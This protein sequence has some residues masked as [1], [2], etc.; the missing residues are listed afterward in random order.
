MPPKCT[1]R[2]APLRCDRPRVRAPRPFSSGHRRRASD[3]PAAS[4]GTSTAR[5]RRHD[6]DAVP[7]GEDPTLP[8]LRGFR[9]PRLLLPAFIVEARPDAKG[10]WSSQAFVPTPTPTNPSNGAFSSPDLPPPRLVARLPLL[11]GLV[12]SKAVSPLWA[13][14]RP[15]HRQGAMVGSA[16]SIVPRPRLFAAARR[17]SL[18]CQPNPLSQLPTCDPRPG[19]VCLEQLCLAAHS[20]R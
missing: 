12:H 13:T 7:P 16:L 20:R 11:H 4:D 8:S 1:Q 14:A 3:D 10:L 6:G 18:A 15:S 9:W 17:P 2:S 19:S 5:C